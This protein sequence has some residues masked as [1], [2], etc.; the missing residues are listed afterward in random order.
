VIGARAA[1][2]MR[3]AQR[4]STGLKTRHYEERGEAERFFQ[5]ADQE[6]PGAARLIQSMVW[7]PE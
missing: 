7:E 5:G 1:Q 4:K 2:N 6:E 3:R